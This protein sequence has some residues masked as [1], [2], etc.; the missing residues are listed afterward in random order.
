MS[1][2]LVF[3]LALAIDLIFGEPPA[4]IHPVVLMGRA[5]SF[6]KQRSHPMHIYG[7]A[8]SLIMVVGSAASGHLMIAAASWIPAFFRLESFHGLDIGAIL[9]TIIASYLLKSCFAFRS[10][11]VTSRDIGKAIEE[12]MDLAR[13]MLPALVGR[14]TGGLNAFLARSAV[15]ESLSENF[16]D[17]I[18]S[19]LFYFI[20]FSPVGLGVEAALAFKAA[21][22]MDSMLG[23]KKPG[24]AEIGLIPARLDDIL[25]WIPA[26]LSI[27]I[28]AM[29]MPLKAKDALN[30]AF[31][32][33]RV[34]P[35]PNSGWPMAAA[36]GALGVRLDKPG[37]YTILEGGRP[38]EASD[39]VKSVRYIGM[40][41]AICVGLT[42][43]V[44]Y[45]C[46]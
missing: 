41:M 28:L 43:L 14:D 38:P 45:L 36:A 3:I 18:V 39:I 12:D 9:S 10:L 16:V 23:Y 2:T 27:I 35:S 32:Y 26:R 1:A 19:P 20:I 25:N 17:T 44:L 8:I 6:L 15:I 4:S 40:A 33:N 5:I 37:Y 42:F 22:T 21:S 7:A 24:F 31:K 30:A 46:L 13:S 11:L 29:A 34:T